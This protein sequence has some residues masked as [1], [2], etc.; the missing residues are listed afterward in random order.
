MV[1]F[2]LSF[3]FNL[4]IGPVVSALVNKFGCRIISIAGCSLVAIGFFLSA[5]ASNVITLYFT[6]GIL[7]GNLA[8][9]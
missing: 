2:F 6:I 1:I 9:V 7:S 5:F 4:K 8:L 3:F